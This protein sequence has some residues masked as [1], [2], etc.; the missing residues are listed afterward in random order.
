MQYLGRLARVG[1]DRFPK[2][3]LSA[4]PETGF[5]SS[6]GQRITHS[7][8][9]RGCIV[10]AHALASPR[11]KMRFTIPGIP[12]L[13]SPNNTRKCRLAAEPWAT[14]DDDS[15]GIYCRWSVVARDEKL[16]GNLTNRMAREEELQH[17]PTSGI[18]RS[19]RHVRRNKARPN[20][21]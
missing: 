4:W 10:K 9:M 12:H 16:W 15:W 19:R 18:T 20:A 14:K 11:G 13:N 1:D 17:A 2:L 5:R 21:D 7:R 3:L 8:H 6:G